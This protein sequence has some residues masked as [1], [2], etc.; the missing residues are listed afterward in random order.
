MKRKITRIMLLVAAVALC[1]AAKEAPWACKCDCA[2]CPP[3]TVLSKNKGGE[4]RYRGCFKDVNANGKCDASVREGG[5]CGNDCEKVDAKDG[6]A[7]DGDEKKTV[8]RP[9][10]A[11]C[12]CPTNCAQCV[13]SP[14]AK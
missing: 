13:L 12:P 1:I 11:G 5:K 9:P 4:Y 14:E 6:D 2:K 3:K 10:C 7:K 8:P